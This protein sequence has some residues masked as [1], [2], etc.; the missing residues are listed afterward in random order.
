MPSI[1]VDE[2]MIANYWF[3]TLFT[4]GAAEVYSPAIDEVYESTF[5]D[6]FGFS[7]RP[8]VKVSEWKPRMD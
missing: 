6:H 7:I 3:R 4:R 5:Y 1:V 2:L 8:R